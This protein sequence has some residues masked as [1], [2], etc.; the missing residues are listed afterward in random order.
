MNFF[1][2]NAAAYNS[3]EPEI[4]LAGPAGTGKSIALLVKCLTL[5]GKY[6]NSRGLFCR[7]TRTSLTQSGLVTWEEKV[8][9]P[10]HPVLIKRPV[11]RRVRQSYQFPNGSEFVIAGLDD[12]GKTL[13]AEYDFVYIQEATEEGISLAAY[14]TLLR[15]LRNGRMTFT[16]LMMDCNPTTPT[17]WLYRRHTAGKLKLYTSSHEDNPAFYDRNKAEWTQAGRAYLD[18]LDRMSGARRNR[19]RLGLWSAA[20]GLIYDYSPNVHNLPHGWKAPDHWRRF[21]AI[22]WGFRDPLVI[23]FWAVDGDGRMYLYRE[24]FKTETRVETAARWCRELMDTGA[25]PRPEAVITDHDPECVA[26]FEKYAGV[27]CTPAEKN[28]RDGGIQFAQARFDIAGDDRPRIFFL[29]DARC[30][31]ADRGLDDNGRPTSTLEEL[32]GYIW[33]PSDPDKP[34]DEPISH[35]DHG[36]D[37]LRYLCTHL[38]GGSQPDPH[39]YDAPIDYGINRPRY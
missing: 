37:A 27:T 16:Q 19:F 31:P 7:G 23:Q 30:H 10:D 26:T 18:T 28:D 24:H 14:E 29:P 8:L 22:D 3:R 15:L 9:G 4:L 39:F 12:P 20:E 21:W 25:E 35:N 13:S 36:M 32:I 6:P 38:D 34:K 1:G 33:K 5:L 2:G 17:H 11:L